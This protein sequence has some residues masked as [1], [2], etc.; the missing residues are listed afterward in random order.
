LNFIGKFLFFF[1]LLFITIKVTAQTASFTGTIQD[2]VTKLPIANAVIYSAKDTITVRSDTAGNFTFHFDPHVSDTL[3]VSDSD[4]ENFKFVCDS[5][6]KDKNILILLQPSPSMSLD[7]PDDVGGINFKGLIQDGHTNEPIGYASVYMERTGYGKSADSL[8]N[9]TFHFDEFKPDTLVVSY[10]GYQDYKLPIDSSIN[11]K[12]IL[13]LLQRGKLSNEV[14]VRGRSI[15]RGLLLWR[16]IMKHKKQYDRTNFSNFSYEAYNKLEVDIK[17]FNSKR[18]ANNFFL[19]PFSFVFNNIDSQSESVPF[20]PVYLLE[21]VSNYSYQK[22]PKKYYENILASNTKGFTNQSISKLLGVMNQNVN[23]Y[24]NYITVIDKD[25][26]SPLNDEAF[27]YYNFSTP[28]TQV[29]AGKKLYHFVFSPKRPGQSTF[30]G[31]AWITEK[32]YQIE[33]ISLY[34]GKDANINY[35]TRI[36][37]FQEFTPIGDSMYFLTRD[38][39]FADF[40]VLGKQSLTFIGR[41]TTSY[42]NIV[43]NSDSITNLL[44]KQKIEELTTVEPG[45]NNKSDSDWAK[46]RHDTLSKNEQAIYTTVDKL[47]KMPK[48]INRR[49]EVQFLVTGYRKYGNFEI[50]PWFNWLSVNQWEGTRYR[51]DLGT[52][53]QVMKNVYLHGYLAYGTKDEKLKGMGEAYWVAN[54]YPKRLTLHAKYFND[55]DYGISSLGQIS[56]DNIFTVAIRKPNITRK[57]ISKQEVSFDVYKELGAGFSA[58]AYL[59]DRQYTPLENLPKQNEFPTTNGFPMSS[60]SVAL[61][62][63]FAY[64]EQFI[65]GDYFQYSL[66]TSKYPIV[67]VMAEQGVPGILH[68]AYNYTK[69]SVNIGD[70]IKIPPYGSITYKVYAGKVFGTVPYPF[71]AN[72]PGNDLYYYDP[73]SFNLMTRFEYLADQYTGINVEHNF[74][75]GLFRFI[76]LTRK[77]KWRQ[78][79]NVK[80]V[81]GSLSN[82]NNQLNNTDNSF[83]ILNAKSYIEIGTGIDNIFRVLRLDLVWRVSPG[84]LP[85]DNSTSHF[86][87][88]GSFHFQF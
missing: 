22:S 7:I 48:F 78:F 46:L 68:S 88:F 3:V 1:L 71:L 28:D 16:M 72:L 67:E 65:D 11:D 64:L 31:D 13:V 35:I 14:V 27:R 32:T 55:I 4:Y 19:K 69:V 77:L 45:V 6:I 54:R 76:P 20:L 86:G 56:Q 63:R 57:F 82:A 21:T 75:S 79:W 33:K 52:T 18:V 73:Q 44:G 50:G 53:P 29:V 5:T 8:G 80:A 47:L 58:Q 9:F 61:K 83:K 70:V 36:S 30:Q 10:V 39:F 62:L 74:G 59:S 81:W 85:T 37:V 38:K 34:L 49:K 42:K 66:G 15:G 51:F 23:V 12:K 43:V 40:N 60:F 84:P 25:F 24:D 87:I 26:I 17:N 41:K 2:G